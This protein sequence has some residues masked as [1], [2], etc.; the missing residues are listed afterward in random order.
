MREKSVERS[1]GWID[2]IRD[3][4]F[5]A[6]YVGR[7]VPIRTVPM[8]PI[9]HGAITSAPL[10][11]WL[12]SALTPAIRRKV[13]RHELHHLRI[14]EL[15]HNDMAAATYEAMDVLEDMPGGSAILDDYEVDGQVDGEEALAFLADYYADGHRLPARTS[16]GLRSVLRRITT[17]RP[18]VALFRYAAP[19]AAIV[20]A[21]ALATLPASAGS[22]PYSPW[23]DS[24]GWTLHDA[25]GRLLMWRSCS[26]LTAGWPQGAAQDDYRAAEA[27]GE[28]PTRQPMPS[29]ETVAEWCADRPSGAVINGWTPQ[30]RDNWASPYPVPGPAVVIQ[31]TCD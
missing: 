23:A 26:E 22:V 29:C 30:P 19:P 20:A 2:T 5:T 21:I 15:S 3:L 27:R 14:W 31:I 24:G 12:S 9:Q 28:R 4:L 10:C 1:P 6:I 11:V 18:W 16:P 13:L 17:P 7:A 8:D 25:K